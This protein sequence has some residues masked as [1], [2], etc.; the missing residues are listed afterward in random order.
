MSL[1]G[2]GPY[3]ADLDVTARL[4][5]AGPEVAARIRLPDAAVLVPQLRGP[6][7]A[8]V[9]AQQRGGVWRADVDASG[10]LGASLNVAG[11]V[12]GDPIAVDVDLRVPNIAALVPDLPGPLRVSGTVAQ[13]GADYRVDLDVAGPSGTAAQVAGSIATDGQLG[14]TVSGSAPLGLANGLA[15]PRRLGGVAQ[16]D[17]AINGPPSLNAVTGTIRTTDAALSLPTLRNALDPIAATI[18]LNNGQAQ[19]DATAQLQTGGRVAITG[20][21]QLSAPFNANLA[22]R[23]GVILQDPK[24]YTA[25]LEGNIALTGPLAGGA[26]VSGQISIE[27]AEIAVPSSGLTAIG[28][29]PPIDHLATPRPVRRT[30]ERAGQ[31]PAAQAAAAAPSGPGFGLDLDITA[32]GRIFVR[33]R[34]LDAELGGALRLTGTTNAPITSGAFELVRGRLDILQ[35]RFELDEG[36]ITFQG[37]LTPYIRLVVVTETDAL[38]ASIA[39]EGPADNISV[40]F[41]STPTVPQEEILA[42]IFFGRDLSQLS[43][44]QALQ[45]ANSVA[46]LAGRGNGGLLEKLR[47]GTG[48]D[49]L[50]VTTDAEGNTALRAGKY[51]SDNVYTDVQVGQNGDAAIS[52]NI[53]L[54]PNLTV[55]GSTSAGGE[56]SLGLFF[57]KDY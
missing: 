15:A 35:Q 26:L 57:E 29:L 42:Q 27:E 53:D 49:D 4:P 2:T 34:G 8:T 28:D 45:L 11:V 41:G 44:L 18:T 21:V 12:A 38:T 33:G 1:A 16:F 37:D 24:L 9:D 10:P 36:T 22:A 17:L 6:L 48:L 51:I 19:V 55:R 14:L 46:I 54:T 32:P 3:N 43:P 52:L 30:L 39:V 47:G 56:N 50:D 23:F 25:T 5:E 20:P 7:T 40:N 31:G 13:A